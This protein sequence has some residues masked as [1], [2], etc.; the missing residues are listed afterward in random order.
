MSMINRQLSFSLDSWQATS[1]T[2]ACRFTANITGLWAFDHS[3]LGRFNIPHTTSTKAVTA[4]APRA[5][6]CWPCPE[7]PHFR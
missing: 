3:R 7:P 6:R 4:N 1:C 2:E 5:F